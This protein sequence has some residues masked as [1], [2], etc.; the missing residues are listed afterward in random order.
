M[1]EL[2]F[3]PAITISPKALTDLMNTVDNAQLPYDPFQKFLIT[4]L[5]LNP[6]TVAIAREMAA[7]GR[8]AMLDSGGYYVQTGKL[9]YEDLYEPLLAIYRKERWA[10]TYTLPDHVLTSNDSFETVEAKVADT[11]A[12]STR[13]FHALPD[14]LK[15]RALPVVQGYTLAQIDRC[16]DAYFALGVSKIGFGSFNT[17]GSKST[18]NVVD[19]QAI[20]RITHVIN[21]AHAEGVK[22]H[23]FGIGSPP[24]TAM[25][26]GVGAD[27]FDT[28]SWMLSA[29]LGRVTLPFIRNYHISLRRPPSITQPAFER[30]KKITTHECP[31]CADFTQIRDHRSHRVL[32]NLLSLVESTRI[33]ND[34]NNLPL[35]Q[36]IYQAGSPRY[37]DY[38][39][40]WLNPARPPT[41]TQMP[42]F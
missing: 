27:T 13:F 39:D 37:K 7:S 32:H 16:L 38:F 19:E 30:L 2:N 25:L 3:I 23:L 28:S 31:A 14:E 29:G 15:P 17:K 5:L 21:A 41:T 6:V 34:P 35:I 18:M 1:T 40:R 10:T 11:I 4:P 9:R 8:Q 12:N 22:V 20:R 42:L 33:V 24:Y 36:K 26:K